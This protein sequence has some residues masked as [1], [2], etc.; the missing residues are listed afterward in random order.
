MA[1]HYNDGIQ[2][3]GEC[4]TVRDWC[5]GRGDVCNTTNA[6]V[7]L[8]SPALCKNAT[9]WRINNFSCVR[10][11]YNG[12]VAGAGAR[13]SGDFQHCSWPWYRWN[14]YRTGYHNPTCVDKSDQ[15]FPI[16]TTC[17]LHNKQFLETYRR[18]W[19]SG[20]ANYRGEYCYLSGKWRVE[21]WFSRQDDDKI[22]DP[23]GCINSCKSTKDGPNC[24]ACEHPDF[25][26]CNST[27][28]F[29]LIEK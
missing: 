1:Y 14:D 15:V 28:I 26:H 4:K 24:L 8:D 7:S 19:C 3:S 5:T 11:Y 16:N 20:K 6:I 29:T 12:Q 2:C 21:N 13:C 18:I 22:L 23:H 27:G 17:S 10:T 25:F 9:Y